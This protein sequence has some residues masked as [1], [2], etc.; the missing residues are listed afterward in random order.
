MSTNVKPSPFGAILGVLVAL[1]IG[2]FVVR[3]LLGTLFFFGRIAILL[4][5]VAA[6][7]SALTRL[8]RK[9]K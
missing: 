4:V 5:I 2:W 6:V 9:S 7:A 8:G 3:S 1:V